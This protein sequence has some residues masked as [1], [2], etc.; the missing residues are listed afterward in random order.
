LM[1]TDGLAARLALRLQR[2][3]SRNRMFSSR[4]SPGALVRVTWIHAD[5]LAALHLQ[6]F[7]GF[8]PAGLGGDRYRTDST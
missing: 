5:G 4:V 2:P 3:R 8:R 7:G 6:K 1:H